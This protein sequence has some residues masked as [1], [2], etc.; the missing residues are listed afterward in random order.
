MSYCSIL[1]ENTDKKTMAC[2]K[3]S[4]NLTKGHLDKNRFRGFSLIDN[5]LNVAEDCV[6]S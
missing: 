5:L 6:A 1:V 4:L 2:A 3:L